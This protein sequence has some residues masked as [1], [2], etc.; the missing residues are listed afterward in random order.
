MLLFINKPFYKSENLMFFFIVA[1][2]TLLSCRNDEA[3]NELNIAVAANMKTPMDSI[4]SVFE[5]KSRIKC[6]LY[7][8]S[9]GTLNVQIIQGAPYDIFFSA[10]QVYPVKLFEKGIAKAPILYGKG[11]LV[12]VS[13]SNMD[14][15]NL[16]T[17]LE[18][19]EINKIAVAFEESA[20]YGLA[21]METL[22]SLNLKTDLIDKI[23]IGESVGQVNQLFV[24]NAVD[25]A[26]TSFSFIKSYSEPF[27][28]SKVNDTLYSPIL[29]SAAVIS[30]KN[31]KK[32][33]IQEKFISFLRTNECKAILNY[34]G[35]STFD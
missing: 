18:S 5:D 3:G 32:T 26:F 16:A 1:L 13:H 24:S 22:E 31:S 9:S 11:S 14:N 21:G 25:A 29:Q 19:D 30:T 12:L 34:Y 27:Y 17:L 10:N 23:V 20:P 15:Q 4:V 6:N 7:S 28:Y 8:N 2:C 35:Y 33:M